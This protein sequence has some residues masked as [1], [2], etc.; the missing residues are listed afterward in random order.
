M[1]RKLTKQWVVKHYP[2]RICVPYC[3]IQSL[4]ARE[5]RIG[6]TTRRE[7]WGANIYNINGIAIVTG[8]A[9]F[10]NVK[11]SYELCQKYNSLA[12]EVCVNEWDC[13]KAR[14]ILWKLL[15]EFI[16]EARKE[17]K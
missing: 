14:K 7:G 11:P 2:I 12:H 8:Y 15:H 9:P 4:L 13:T 10:G 3:A 5:D 1:E 6:Y 17:I 16:A